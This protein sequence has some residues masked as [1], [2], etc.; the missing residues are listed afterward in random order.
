VEAFHVRGKR[1]RLFKLSAG[2]PP[3]GPALTEGRASNYRERGRLVEA[4]H[5]RGKRG[6]LFKLSAGLPHW[7][8]GGMN[9]V[10][11]KARQL[12]NGLCG[13]RIALKRANLNLG[14]DFHE[15]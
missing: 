2:L 10:C 14:G 3:R 4:F 6:R 1:G 5:V 8:P 7:P 9:I 12:Q 11:G 15:I 13:D